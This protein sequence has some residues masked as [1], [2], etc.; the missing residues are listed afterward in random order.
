MPIV[1]RCTCGKALSVKD[2]LA[3]KRVRCPACKAV[4]EVPPAE[5]AAPARACPGCGKALPPNAVIC[6]ECGYDTRTGKRLRGVARPSDAT[7]IPS[8]RSVSELAQ[9]EP[10]AY[11]SWG[12]LIISLCLAGAAGALIAGFVSGIVTVH[13]GLP[14]SPGA[15]A[16]ELLKPV[17]LFFGGAI[18]GAFLGT[19]LARILPK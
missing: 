4:L 7:P 18:A 8:R 14:E 3:G 11:R 2:E 19:R 9:E 5:R 17:A 10:R 6:V 15:Q 13:R 16:W 1:V 12:W